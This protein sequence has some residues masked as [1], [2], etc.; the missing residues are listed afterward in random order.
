MTYAKKVSEILPLMQNTANIRNVGILAHIDHGKTTLSDS[1]LAYAGL[2]SPSLAG[3]ARTLD[4]LEEEQ[5]RGI[6]IKTANISLPYKVNNQVF[7]VNLIDTPGHVDFS[8]ARDQSLRVIDGTVIVVDA[9]E[10]IMTQTEV[11]TR[12][13]LEEYIKPTLFIN[14]V[15][16]LI[17]ELKL[18]LKEIEAKLN[19]IIQ[20][21]DNLIDLYAINN[22]KQLWRIEASMGNVVFGS[23]L[24]LWGCTVGEMLEKGIKFKNIVNIYQN[25]DP[26]ADYTQIQR[27][28]PLSVNIFNMIVNHIP[29]PIQAQKYRIPNL[30]SGETSTELGQDLLSCNLSGGVL[31]YI[32]K[33]ITDKNLGIISIG[34]LFSGKLALGQEIFSLASR[35]YEKIQ[36]LF[37]YMGP[38]RENIKSVPAGNIVAF[39]IKDPRVGDTLVQKDLEDT[40]PFEKVKYETEAVV[41]YSIEPL[42]PR[43]LKAMMN[44]L[45]A[46]SINDPN[47]KIN[48]N[49]ETG[50]I[51][52]SGL[53][54]LHLEII[55]SELKKEGIEI[56]TSD[57]IVTHRETIQERSTLTVNSSDS[58]NS[59]TI[60]IEPLESQIIEALTTG[61]ITIKMS[62]NRRRQILEKISSW[63]GDEIQRLFYCDNLGNIMFWLEDIYYDAKVMG[64]IPPVIYQN[65][66]KIF[67]FGPLVHD[68]LRGIKIK[69]LEVLIE[70][71]PS[72]INLLHIIPLLKQ[73]ITES[74]RIVKSTLLQPIYKIQ[75]KTL[76]SY[77][78]VISSVLSQSN[79]KILQIE[80][81]GQNVF[82]DGQIPVQ[83]TFGLA[84][85][86]RSKTSGHISFL[87]FFSH[88]EA[89][90]PESYMKE[91]IQE[92]RE[93]RGIQD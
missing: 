86:L 82:I 6:T 80:Q 66:E 28:L 24:H 47:L 83:K 36:Q 55:V 57:P 90:L 40:I 17:T 85:L 74:F 63:D 2:L 73:A 5:K 25:Q 89:I 20:D 71:E 69:I 34:R 60:Q 54:E 12:Q 49:E 33:N 42:H 46:I 21:F 87:T 13:A 68:P 23:A 4:F 62:E 37:L 58:R 27:Q 65:F 67:R 43:D 78:G 30:W 39:N 50:E 59:I 18:S 93:S 91:L 52:I 44:L 10:G 16:R 11:V 26:A 9:V 84:S 29:N 61:Q 41:Q 56:I 7:L 64:N 75:I 76:P 1:L 79:G 19:D 53:G 38:Y 32:Y 3:E 70:S 92:L 14:K 72:Q 8:G 35:N 31:L 48:I 45:K 22:F 81:K 51:L 15:D 88:W 77:I